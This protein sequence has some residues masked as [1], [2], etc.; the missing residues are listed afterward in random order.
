MSKPS[1]LS[2]LSVHGTFNFRKF[3]VSPFTY[4]HPNIECNSKNIPG[5]WVLARI[6]GPILIQS[7]KKQE[8]NVT[9]FQAAARECTVENEKLSILTNVEQALIDSCKISFRKCNLYRCTKHFKNNC[10]EVLNKI[11]HPNITVGFDVG[12][13]ICRNWNDRI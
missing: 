10:E 11:C 12:C 4:R 3:E 6:I 13:S 7:N 2:A 8:T 5:K 1:E 9:G